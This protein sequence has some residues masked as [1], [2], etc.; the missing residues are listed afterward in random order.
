MIKMKKSFIS[1]RWKI[2][3]KIH[4]ILFYFL[5]GGFNVEKIIMLEAGTGLLVLSPIQVIH[6]ISPL[7]TP[8]RLVGPADQPDGTILLEPFEEN[9]KQWAANNI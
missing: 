7:L 5:N 6:G 1:R 4:Q 2:N 9:L 8:V 3:S